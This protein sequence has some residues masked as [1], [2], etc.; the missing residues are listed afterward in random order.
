M[1]T[2]TENFHHFRS[3]ISRAELVLKVCLLSSA[4][5]GAVLMLLAVIGNRSV[6]DVV[7]NVIPSVGLLLLF[8]LLARARRDSSRTEGGSSD[9][10]E[11]V[12]NV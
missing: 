7:G 9:S 3:D 2:N 12:P 1:T 4:G 5:V 6:L 8:Y 11:E 10:S